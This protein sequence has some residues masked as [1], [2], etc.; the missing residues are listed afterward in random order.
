MRMIIVLDKI[1]LL[2][3]ISLSAYAGY[4]AGYKAGKF[5]NEK[6]EGSR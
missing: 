1:C 6:K 4:R 2:G 5:S 3:V